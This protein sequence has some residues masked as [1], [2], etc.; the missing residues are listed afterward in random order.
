MT[1]KSTHLIV[2]GVRKYTD[3]SGTEQS[4][5]DRIGAMFPNSKGGFRIKLQYLPTDPNIDI[6]A[7][8][9][10]PDAEQG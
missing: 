1:T 8:P 7:M 2:Y 3:E 10:K 5:W 4:Q 9:P 6:V